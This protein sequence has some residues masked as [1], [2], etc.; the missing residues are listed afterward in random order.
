MPSASRCSDYASGRFNA[1]EQGLGA[2]LGGLLSLADRLDDGGAT[3]AR[4]SRSQLLQSLLPTITQTSQSGNSAPA[5]Q[6][7]KFDAP[8]IKR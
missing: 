4:R 5:T 8:D 3:K 1:V 6:H 2:E 7:E